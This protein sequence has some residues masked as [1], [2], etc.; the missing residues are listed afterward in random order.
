MICDLLSH[1]VVKLDGF[2]NVHDEKE[3]MSEIVRVYDQLKGIES[4]MTHNR[5]FR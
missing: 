5:V 4:G 2:K 1:G 3:C